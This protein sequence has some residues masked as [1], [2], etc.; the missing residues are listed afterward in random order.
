MQNAETKSVAK[1][2]GSRRLEMADSGYMLVP[3]Q[4]GKFGPERL[5]RTKGSSTTMAVSTLTHLM[6]SQ[7]LRRG[8][9]PDGIAMPDS[10]RSDRLFGD[11]GRT[12]YRSSGVKMEKLDQEEDYD[13]R[14]DTCIKAFVRLI[15][16]AVTS[17]LAEASA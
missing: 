3:M 5:V 13:P 12:S 4:G 7:K 16:L 11:V 2:S 6:V 1:S 10:R 9:G 15:A 17:A 8:D 14:D